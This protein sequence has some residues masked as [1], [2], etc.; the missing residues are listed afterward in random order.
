[1]WT[2]ADPDCNG[3]GIA[4]R[5]AYRDGNS[6]RYRNSNRDGN[7]NLYLF[8]AAYSYSDAKGYTNGAAPA[9]AKSATNA[10]AKT[11]RVEAIFGGRLE[12]GK[13]VALRVRKSKNNVDIFLR[14]QLKGGFT[15]GRGK[16]TRWEQQKSCCCASD[17]FNQN[18]Y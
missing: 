5:Y 16:L 12:A 11:V 17:C 9:V 4:K 1:M 13:M 6:N 8:S 14:I 18:H 10:A 3:C 2:D 15:I 7:S